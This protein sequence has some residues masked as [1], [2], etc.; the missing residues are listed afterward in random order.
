MQA[1]HR[2]QY[3]FDVAMIE[4]ICT[5]IQRDCH[6]HIMKFDQ[7]IPSLVSG[8]IDLAASGIIIT[9]ERL[10][11]V[12]FSTPYATG[13][14]RFLGKT[15]FLKTPINAALLNKNRIGVTIG[16]PFREEI[17]SL[18]GLEATIIEYQEEVDLI[19]ALLD[20]SIDL[21]LVLNQTALYWQSNTDG[22]LIALGQPINY[23]FG[24]GIAVNLNNSIL[25][26]TINQALK[27]YINSKE[28]LQNFN[29]YLSYD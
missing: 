26:K 24:L 19:E 8:K 13:N 16:S 22:K 28:Y 25:L 11:F 1:A 27:K 18:G 14:S 9:S 10:K 6:L 23:G 4:Y 15:S 7:L 17:Y 12:N 21:A 29:M 20:N 5:L 3:G 2:Q